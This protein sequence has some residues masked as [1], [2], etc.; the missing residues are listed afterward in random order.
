LVKFFSK[1]DE[2][3]ELFDYSSKP[4]VTSKTEKSA[5]LDPNHTHFI[6]VDNSQL[7]VFGGEINFRGKLESAISSY[8]SKYR[9][10]TFE[11][12]ESSKIPIVVLVLEGFLIYS[13]FVQIFL[14]Y[15][16]I[17]HKIFQI[18]VGQTH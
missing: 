11:N 12:G 14:L 7:N 1:E 17:K 2:E 8:G 4:K 6:L 5:P 18:K 3:N 15:F 13:F 9:K 16:E 10:L